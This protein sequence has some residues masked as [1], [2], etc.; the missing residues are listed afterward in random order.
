MVFR[1][2]LRRSG[3]LLGTIDGTHATG[4]AGEPYVDY[5]I[6]VRNVGTDPVMA[7]VAMRLPS[8][9]T[10]VRV[11]PTQ[12]RCAKPD[13]TGRLECSLGW[14]ATGYDRG[15]VVTVRVTYG[16]STFDPIAPATIV[17]SSVA[18]DLNRSNNRAF[19]D[20]LDRDC[21]DPFDA[22]WPEYEPYPPDPEPAPEEEPPAEEDPPPPPGEDPL[23]PPEDPPPPP[24]EPPPPPEEPPPAP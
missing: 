7:R 2:E 23:P 5:R 24:E 19:L 21:P 20:E 14:V 9:V 1:L 6:A 13:A 11:A 8:E 16:C 18:G 22:M 17:A 12:G 4:P 15:A 3:D 10:V